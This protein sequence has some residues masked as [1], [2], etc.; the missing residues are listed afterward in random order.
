M[1][2]TMSTPHTKPHTTPHRQSATDPVRARRQ[3]IA[4]YTL[5]ANRVG[6]LFYALAIATFVIGFAVSFNGAVSAIV[7][8]SLIIGSV[9]L[10]PAIVLGY[11]VKAAER[12]DRERG[13]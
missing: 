7:I 9:L 5:L 8:G 4:K 6:Y 11:A 1:S 2:R 13:L 12:D 10:A 3:K